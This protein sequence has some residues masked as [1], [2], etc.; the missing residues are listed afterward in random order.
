MVLKRTGEPRE[1]ATT[2]DASGAFR[3]EKVLPGSYE[4]QVHHEGFKTATSRFRIG[5]RPPA[6]LKIS[7]SVAELRQKLTVDSQ[8]AQ[9]NTDTSENL[10]TVTLDRQGLEHLP[11]FDQDYV[12]TM[13]RFLDASSV[14]TGGVTLV[15]DGLESTRVP[16]SASAIQEVKI[17]QNPYS[18]EFS[19]P[20]RGRIEIITKPGSQEY[21]GTLNVLFRDYLLN[22]RDPFAVTRPNEQRRIFHS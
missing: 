5:S 12:G 11:I 14:A 8:I 4:V 15:V 17:N 22:A 20:G 10:D 13:S 6:P 18:A 7:L 1:Q 2:T 19:R 16:V 9:V 21:H 3:F